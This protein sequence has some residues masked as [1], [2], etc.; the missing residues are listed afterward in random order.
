VTPEEQNTRGPEQHTYRGD[1]DIHVQHPPPWCQDVIAAVAALLQCLFGPISKAI[2]R[3][4][5]LYQRSKLIKQITVYTEYNSL[6]CSA[7]QQNLQIQ[8]FSPSTTHQHYPFYLHASFASNILKSKHSHYRQWVFV[9]AR[10]VSNSL[11]RIIRLHNSLPSYPPS[12]LPSDLQH[13]HHHPHA[14]LAEPSRI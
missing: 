3:H 5:K 6:S 8:D 2:P 14:H 4:L 12:D 1:P 7:R 9:V 13:Q 11:T 10:A